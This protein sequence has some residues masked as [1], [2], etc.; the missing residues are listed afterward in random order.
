MTGAG[1]ERYQDSGGRKGSGTHEL[2]YLLNHSMQETFLQVPSEKPNSLHRFGVCVRIV[3]CEQ[4]T[5]E[6]FLSGM[7]G[8][9]NVS[10]RLQGFTRNNIVYSCYATQQGYEMTHRT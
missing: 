2:C 10:E 6:G 4:S 1:S 5:A 9:N 7:W 3:F 8:S